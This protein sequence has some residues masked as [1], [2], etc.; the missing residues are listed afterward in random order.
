MFEYVDIKALIFLGI[1]I[2]ISFI[3][4]KKENVFIKVFL[5]A[6][7]ILVLY[8]GQSESNTAQENK[9]FFKR[10]KVLECHN[11]GGPFNKPQRYRVSIKDGWELQKDSFIKESLMI[12]ANKC[13]RL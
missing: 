3:G 7:V 9:N 11:G 8:M 4:K 5:W 12:R 10:G 2:A 6:S 1:F 13:E